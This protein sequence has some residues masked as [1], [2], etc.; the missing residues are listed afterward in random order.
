LADPHHLKP[1]SDW[2]AKPWY[3]YVIQLT[4]GETI[5]V[6]VIDHPDNPPSLWH[7]LKPIA[8]V[9]PCIVAPGPVTIDSG[10]VLR[11]RYRVVVHDGPPP[12]DLLARL[13]DDW[14]G[15]SE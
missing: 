6:A 12:M 10:K 15:R 14:R 7:N 11:L 1:E 13:T 2:P 9:N 4:T 5:G 8:M 3:D